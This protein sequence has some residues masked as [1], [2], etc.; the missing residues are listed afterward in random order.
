MHT[1]G[2]SIGARPLMPVS[3]RRSFSITLFRFRTLEDVA[4]PPELSGLFLGIGADA[5]REDISSTQLRAL[6]AASAV[7]AAVPREEDQRV[8]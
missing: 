2:L 5:F 8:G 3:S 6:E 7:E 1:C 4:V